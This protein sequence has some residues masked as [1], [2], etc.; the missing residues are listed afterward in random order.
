MYDINDMFVKPWTTGTGCGLSVLVSGRR[1]QKAELMLSHAWGED[2]EE[3][4]KA[5]MG[6][7]VAKGIPLEAP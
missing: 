7:V 6:H 2:V 1:E 4:Q 3:M 5:V